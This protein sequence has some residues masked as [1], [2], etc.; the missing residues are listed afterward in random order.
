LKTAR[1]SVVI[2]RSEIETMQESNLSLMPEGIFASLTESQVCDLIAYLM[3][4]S[5]VP[6]P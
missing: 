1:E 5:Q 6:L 4:P 3:H 2:D